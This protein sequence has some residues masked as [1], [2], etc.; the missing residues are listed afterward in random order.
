MKYLK[1]NTNNTQVKVEYLE[2]DIAYASSMG[3]K[4]SV[5]ADAMNESRFS[6]W[7]DISL[8]VADLLYIETCKIVQES[9]DISIGKLKELILNKSVDIVLAEI[10]FGNIIDLDRSWDWHDI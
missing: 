7:V 2:T 10:E 9:Q 3:V 4:V 6:N 5:I 1:N 8:E